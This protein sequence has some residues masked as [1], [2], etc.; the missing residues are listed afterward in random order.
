MSYTPTYT[1]LLADML[2]YLEEDSTEFDAAAPDIINRAELRV[3][4]DLDL[5]LFKRTTDAASLSAAT[6]NAPSGA[7]RVDW[8]R[9][10]TN[11]VMLQKRSPDYVIMHGGTGNPIY[12]CEEDDE[13]PTL[14]VAPAPTAS[15]VNVTVRYLKRVDPLVP[16]TNETNWLTDNVG[17]LLLYASLMGAE[18]FLLEPERASEFERDYATHLNMALREYG[19]IR[20]ADYAPVEP[21]AQAG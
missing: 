5:D 17:D 14:R 16:T 21:A 9:D 12:F 7:I 13:T 1:Q 8:V 18:R 11:S 19:S 6:L 15:A 2:G 4:R 3:Q 20:S 10:E